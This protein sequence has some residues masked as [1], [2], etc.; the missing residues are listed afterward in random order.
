MNKISLNPFI[1]IVVL[2]ITLIFGALLFHVVDRKKASSITER[3][4]IVTFIIIAMGNSV[5]PLSYL[6][7]AALPIPTTKLDSPT[8]LAQIVFYSL[9]ALLLRSKFVPFFASLG[10]LLGNPFL[11]AL[12]LFTTLS[13]FWSETPDVTLKASLVLV[14]YSFIASYV[15]SHYNFQAI[16]TFVRQAGTFSMVAGALAAL[17]VPSIGRM[18]EGGEGEWQGLQTHKNGFAFWMALTSALWF[19][20]AINHQ[21][22]RRLSIG[23]AILSFFV[24]I[25]TQSGASKPMF[26]LMIGVILISKLVKYLRR[27][28]FRKFVVITLFITIFSG[29][30]FAIVVISG[31]LILALLG[32]D[33]SLTGRTDFWPQLMQAV[34]RKPLLGYGYAGFWQSWRGYDNPARSIIVGSS[35]FVPPHAHNGYLEILLSTGFIGIT[36]FTLS[37]LTTI[38]SFIL[39]TRHSRSGEAETAAILL[40]FVLLSSFSESKLWLINEYTLIFF[41]LSIRLSIDARRNSIKRISHIQLPH[42]IL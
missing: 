36:L 24:M 22:S 2:L 7:P 13:A 29:L 32:K 19:L 26:L 34:W 37:L 10:S 1:V 42:A 15:A 40:I 30:F 6:N 17:L 28:N 35:E 3:I 11:G 25:P 12:L 9:C 33:A 5:I 20:H 18:Y 38:V 16:G 8:C 27:L 23:L 31:P 4:F 39:L 14:G 21:K 41:I